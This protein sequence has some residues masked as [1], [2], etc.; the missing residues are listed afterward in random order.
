MKIEDESETSSFLM[1]G[2]WRA[3]LGLL[4]GSEIAM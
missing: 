4:P 3:I 1:P 2:D